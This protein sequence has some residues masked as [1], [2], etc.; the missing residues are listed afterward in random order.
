MVPQETAVYFLPFLPL[1][2]AV[3]MSLIVLAEIGVVVWVFVQQ[4]QVSG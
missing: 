1:Q 2:F 4:E 3:V